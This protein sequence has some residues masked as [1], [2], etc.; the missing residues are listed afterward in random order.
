MPRNEIKA[1]CVTRNF[2]V[3]EKCDDWFDH[4]VSVQRPCAIIRRGVWIKEDHVRKIVQ[5]YSLWRAVSEDEQEHYQEVKP[6]RLPN[7]YTVAREFGGFSEI[8]G[9]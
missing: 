3:A 1:I 6:E 8:I 2:D 9:G 7:K 4:M 5:K